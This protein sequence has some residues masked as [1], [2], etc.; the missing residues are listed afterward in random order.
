MSVATAGE[1]GAD[2]FDAVS[3][4]VS[5]ARVGA[6]CGVAL[7]LGAFLSVLHEILVV[8]GDPTR[9]YYVVAGA[10]LAGTVLAGLIRPRTAALLGAVAVL[11]GTY[12]YVASLPGGAE[13][14]ALLSPMLDDVVALLSGLSVLRIVNADVWAIAA[15]PGPVF[16]A[17]YLGLRRHYVAAGAVGAGA[18]AV[19]V[20]TG[21]A[22]VETT[23]AGVLGV[24]LA[25]ALGDCD[26]RGEA[27]RNADGVV[28]VLATMV[29]LTLVIG[30]VPGAAGALFST[31]GFGFGSE[32]ETMESSLVYAGENIAVTGPVE[33]S[34]EVRYTVEADRAAYW[35]VG[36]Y[37]R[38]TGGGWVRTGTLRNYRGP[39]EGPPGE[40]AE[41]Q[42]RYT[43]ETDI[44]T[45]P[46]AN[47]PTEIRD[48]PVPVQ[49]TEA[50]SFQPASPLHPGESY[51]VRSQVPTASAPE[52]RA[53]DAE[54]PAEIRERY[55]QLPSSVPDRVEERT[56]RLTANA[57]NDYDTARVLERWFRED[58]GYS[59]DV[60]R[61]RGDV[62]DTFLFEMDE[63]Y[64]T[65]FA[66]TMVTMLRTQDI[67]ARFATGYTAGQ[68]VDDGEWVVRGYNS[69]AWVEVYFPGH[70]WVQF[71]P[72]PPEPREAAERQRLSDARGD[73]QSGDVDTNESRSTPDD[74]GTPESTPTDD[75][76]RPGLT[77]TPGGSTPGGNVTP[78][79]GSGAPGG[80]DGD[81]GTLPAIPVPTPEQV[82]FG[83]VVLAGAAVGA[84]RTGA[85]TRLYREVWL[86]RLP[87]GDP[88]TV[89][90]GAYRRLVHLE[91][92][93][94]RRKAP[95]ETPRQFLAGTDDRARRI[96][97]L[98][99]RA[100]YGHG[101]DDADAEAAAELLA[102]LLEERS[103]I[104][105]LVGR[106]GA[107]S[108]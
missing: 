2:A 35:R 20:L 68:R 11:G 65:Y 41:L 62:A 77:D 78:P 76:N 33:L 90:A 93:A 36:T 79:G 26:R 12:L 21:D 3:G 14:L 103:R 1:T 37:D 29:V 67:P 71:D 70:G 17:W 74:P 108:R 54:G 40:S 7:V 28:V 95:G 87:D 39:L 82:G 18:L 5:P 84:R 100:E 53:A 49:V 58:Y 66:T 25:A 24:T 86:R 73:D 16:L 80:D 48:A 15:A 61:P 88:G 106:G 23:L 60:Q 102:E 64:C 85:G 4:R 96:G 75:P 45:L 51:A 81:E 8:T 94:G 13:F 52:L 99:E 31:E 43:A 9:L 42:Q 105:H 57:E 10:A 56:S 30:A 27:L 91:E 104:P 38:Y 83:L 44:A 92:R 46:A 55:T 6:L 34:P 101:V 50:G 89:V 47:K 22:T 97:T 72:T 107:G 69:H 19:V 63:G 32:S 59:L 98:Y